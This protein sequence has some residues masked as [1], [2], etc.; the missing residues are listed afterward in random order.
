M[1]RDFSWNKVFGFYTSKTKNTLLQFF[2]NQFLL[3]LES[4]PQYVGLNVKLV[5]NFSNFN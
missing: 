2:S 4:D 5:L 3:Y 1:L